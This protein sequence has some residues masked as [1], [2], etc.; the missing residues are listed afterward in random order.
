MKTNDTTTNERNTP[1]L[2]FLNAKHVCQVLSLS[3]TSL[4]RLCRSEQFPQARVLGPNRIAW[5]ASDIRKWAKSRPV[6]GE[7]E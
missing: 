6:V 5:L 1:E 7:E 3:R 2:L 4:W